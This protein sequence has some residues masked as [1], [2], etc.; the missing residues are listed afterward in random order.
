MELYAFLRIAGKPL[1]RDI[2]FLAAADEETG[3]AYGMAYVRQIRPELFADAVVLNEGGGF[4]LRIHGRDYITLTVGEKALCRVRLW[5][6]GRGGHAGNPSDD[7]AIL[8]LAEGIRRIFAA[9]SALQLGSDAVRRTM[10][11]VLGGKTPDNAVAAGIY[12]YTGRCGVGMRDYRIGQRGNV[13]PALAEATLEL[14]LLPRASAA[15]ALAFVG[16][17]LAGSGVDFELLEYQPGFESPT[18]SALPM[19]EAA[20]EKAGARFTALP[21]LA[22]GRTDGRFFGGAGSRVYGC[23]PVLMDDAFDV[24]L[25]KV[26]GDDE[27]ISRASFRFG[28]AVID[29]LLR[30]T[31][32]QADGA[33]EP[34][35]ET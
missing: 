13:L 29:A 20:C 23:S 22:L 12:A 27:S 31:C 32:T 18:A 1:C 21:M 2:W 14:K 15:E 17:Q 25:P 8:K 28:C 16:E 7:Q 26:H 5:A 6:E 4:P 35:F 30:E 10:E 3:G 34:E 24:T 19:L 9:E 11:K 33:F